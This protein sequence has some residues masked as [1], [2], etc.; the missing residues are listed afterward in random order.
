ML[1]A[2]R[3]FPLTA[4]GDKCASPLFYGC[5]LKICLYC[6]HGVD[7]T[8][9]DVGLGVTLP[10]SS[11][12]RFVHA[13]HFLCSCFGRQLSPFSDLL[14]LVQLGCQTDDMA[15]IGSGLHDRK[16]PGRKTLCP[17]AE[18]EAPETAASQHARP[19]RFYIASIENGKNSRWES[20][21][22][23]KEMTDSSEIC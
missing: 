6:Q 18:I 10:A 11:I 19:S 4:R 7:D 8:R 21:D 16:R 5:V 20:N 13:S 14:R 22:I 3:P 9:K 1:V 2:S 15:C 17:I 12:L 23:S